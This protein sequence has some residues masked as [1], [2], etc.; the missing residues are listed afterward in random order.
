MKRP[1]SG[2]GCACQISHCRGC[3]LE[4]CLSEDQEE[5]LRSRVVSGQKGCFRQRGLLTWPV[6][7]V[8][9]GQGVWTGEP[10]QGWPHRS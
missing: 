1:V 5:E 7:C 10:E 9:G 3:I 6:A 4:G 8:A 2:W